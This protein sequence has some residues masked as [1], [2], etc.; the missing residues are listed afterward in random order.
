[1]FTNIR[2][3]LSYHIIHV[4]C[5]ACSECLSL[6]NLRSNTI[7]VQAETKNSAIYRQTPLRRS[8]TNA[9][10]NRHVQSTETLIE[11]IVVLR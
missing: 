11:D 6:S 4:S 5:V 8:R 3:A 10:V 1:M 7:G 2:F 9:V